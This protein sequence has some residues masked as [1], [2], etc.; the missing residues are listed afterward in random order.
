MAS[1]AMQTFEIRIRFAASEDTIDAETI[2]DAIQKAKSN[3]YSS[4]YVI[5]I[6]AHNPD[7]G[8]RKEWVA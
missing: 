1:T 4:S 3:E 2:D 5:A 8:Q 6:E 7:T